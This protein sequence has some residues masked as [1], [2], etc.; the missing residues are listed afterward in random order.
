[1]RNDQTA[2]EKFLLLYSFYMGL[3]FTVLG[4]GW[5]LAIHSGVILFD[6]I[7]S[8]MSIILTML[9]IFA[10]RLLNQPDDDTF[11]FGRM[12]FEPLVVAFKSIVII[13]VCMYGVVTA[14]ITIVNGGEEFTD[15]AGGMLYGLVAL[16]LCLC[17]WLYLKRMGRGLPD[18]VQAESEQW[19][20][21]TMLS[22]AVM[23]SFVFSYFLAKTDWNHLA[24]YVDPA[25]V[26][27]GSGYFVRVPLKR[28]VASIR[29]LLLA[30]PDRGLQRQ[31]EEHADAL[32]K[33]RGFAGAVVRSSKIGRELAVDIA[34]IGHEEM[35]AMKLAELDAIREEVESGLADLELKLWMNVLFTLDRRWA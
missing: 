30:A 24:P 2:S 28:F 6:G 3:V 16:I 14:V 15:S 35:P 4:I 13:I 1:M 26:V 33:S 32:A 27:L 21:D 34:F 25:M 11:Q 17:S 12:A 10:T 5:G 8:G 22:A 31:L 23:A 9:S 19:L 18:L 7:Y 20:M 29:E